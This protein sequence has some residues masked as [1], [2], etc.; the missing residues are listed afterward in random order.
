MGDS[1][2]GL[3]ILFWAAVA[4]IVLFRLRSVLGR[5]TGNERPPRDPLSRG[6]SASA[7]ANDKPHAERDSVIA[8]PMNGRVKPS[9]HAA[10]TR[11]SPEAI[12]IK[13]DSPIAEVLQKIHTADRYFDP[14]EFV[15]GA[16][17]AYAMIIEAF[18]SGDESALK[19]L[20]STEV[21]ANFRSAISGRAARGETVDSHVADIVKAEI[22][23]AALRDTTADITIRF[24][25]DILR[26]VRDSENRVIEGDPTDPSRV[27]D[28]WTFSRDVES[29]DPNWTL[30]ATSTEE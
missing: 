10:E 1:L 28:L 20:L 2:Q 4:G 19:P 25:S 27:T 26:C 8:L 18:A 21:M 22:T 29:A 16:K 7:N 12:G 11:L 3:E 23:D 13:S 14:V 30:I 5:R 15:A 6:S 24:E 17:S 9:P